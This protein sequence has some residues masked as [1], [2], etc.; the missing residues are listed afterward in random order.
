MTPTYPPGTIVVVRPA[1]IDEITIGQAI[2]YQLKSG[3]SAVV[4]HRVIGTRLD[5]FGNREFITQ[6]DANGAPDADP[7]RAVQVRG[8]V[9]YA[10]PKLGYASS[11]ATGEQRQLA[12]YGI[13]ALLLGYAGR[14]F[15]RA[16][17]GRSAARRKSEA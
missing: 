14:M 7:V 6:G 10:I 13:A 8:A 4:T 11:W 9:W 17:L 16:A 2:T 15:L 1:P 12:V 5:E 3:E